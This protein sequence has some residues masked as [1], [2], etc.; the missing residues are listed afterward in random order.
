MAVALVRH[1]GRPD[2][3]QQQRSAPAEQRVQQVGELAVEDGQRDDVVQVEALDEHPHEHGGAGVLEQRVG[4]L[5]Q[6]GRVIDA[7]QMIGGGIVPPNDGL[8]DV[9]GEPNDDLNAHGDEEVLVDAG[10]IVA[11]RSETDIV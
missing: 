1:D 4:G 9:H 7:G 3:R 6:P 10:A 8:I 11:Q 2:G 5:A